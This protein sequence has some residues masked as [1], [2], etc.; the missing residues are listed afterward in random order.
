[1]R[2][3]AIGLPECVGVVVPEL[4]D[5]IASLGR[6]YC[7]DGLIADFSLSVAPFDCSGRIDCGV[8][9]GVHCAAGRHL[10]VRRGDQGVQGLLRITSTA[11]SE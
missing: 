2:L 9:R 8:R 7:P 5:S 1:M 4:K 11:K 6:R 3:N 10:E